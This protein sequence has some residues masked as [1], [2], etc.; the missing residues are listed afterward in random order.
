MYEDVS[1]LQAI[2]EE[3]ALHLQIKE[4][5]SIKEHIDTFKKII[6]DLERVENVEINDKDKAFFMLSSLPKSY[7]GFV[8]TM[9]YG[10]TTLT[11]EDVKASLIQKRFK[12][13]MGEVSNSER[14]FA[15]SEKRNE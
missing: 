1:G 4:G 15:R 13:I 5:T 2:L 9:L 10:R 7:E 11:L 6:I 12:T 8:N 14:L 3:K